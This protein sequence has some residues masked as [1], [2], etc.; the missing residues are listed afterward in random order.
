MIFTTEGHILSLPREYLNSPPP[1]RRK[2]RRAENLRC[3][4]YTPPQY[5]EDESYGLVTTIRSR[6]DA[7]FARLTVGLDIYSHAAE[8]DSHFWFPGG[9]CEMPQV[10]LYVRLSPSYTNSIL[11]KLREKSM[12]FILSSDGS[13]VPEDSSPDSTKL[14]MV[15]DGYVITNMT[16]IRA[17]LTTRLD[18]R[19]YDITRCTLFHYRSNV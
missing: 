1:A 6:G 2:L 7:E 3:P 15:N 4:A 5:P 16:G 19:G 9:W 8:E 18:G 14:Y 17:F 10:D 11:T 13:T 12:D